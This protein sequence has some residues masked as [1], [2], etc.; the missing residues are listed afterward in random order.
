ML[1]Y[2]VGMLTIM[3][4]E[5][6]SFKNIFLRPYFL[7]T[8]GQ[9]RFTLDNKNGA[10]RF[11]F[12][13]TW[14]KYYEWR[15][16]FYCMKISWHEN[17]AVLRS[18][19]KNREIKNAAKNDFMVNREIKMHQ[20]IRFFGYISKIHNLNHVFFRSFWR[21]KAYFHLS[22]FRNREIK[23]PRNAIFGKKP[24]KLKWLRNFHAAN[25]SCNKLV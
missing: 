22:M 11:F 12:S 23:M 18:R 4:D 10:K 1:A 13:V 15:T 7:T 8:M 24:A 19:S 2:G 25:F 9:T 20:K 6:V 5:D 16:I 21:K 14:G 3:I 17:F